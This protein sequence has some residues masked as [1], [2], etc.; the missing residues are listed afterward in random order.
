MPYTPPASQSP[1]ASKTITPSPSET[2]P[3]VGSQQE[4]THRHGSNSKLQLPHSSSSRAYLSK[5]RRSPSISKTASFVPSV[6]TS[7]GGVSHNIST[8]N[9]DEPGY[10]APGIGGN[11]LLSDS[12]KSGSSSTSLNSSDDEVQTRGGRIRDPPNLAEL[13][14]AIAI[15][16]QHREGSPNRDPG[17][18]LKAR[19][20]LGL[21]GLRID[22]S[23]KESSAGPRPSSTQPLSATARKISHSRSSTDVSALL[24]LPKNN[25][26]SPAR[27]ASDSDIDDAEDDP[28]HLKPAMIR[29]KSGE[30]VRPALRPSC[31]RRR[32]SSMPGTPTY[33]KAVHFDSSLE[34]VRHFLQVDRPIAVSAGTSPVDGHEDDTEFPFGNGYL[35]NSGRSFEWEIRLGNFPRGTVERNL[36]PVKVEKIYLSPDNKNLMAGIAVANL[37]FHKLV[38]A[39]FTLDYWKTTSEVVADYNNDV[40]RKQTNDGRDRFVFS[41]KLEDQANLESKT[42]F[43]CVRYNVNGQEFWDNNDSMNYQVD[44]TKKLNSEANKQATQGANVGLPRSKSSQSTSSSRPLSFPTANDDFGGFGSPFELTPFPQPSAQVIGESPI[45]LKSK[46]PTAQILPDAPGRRTNA[47]GQ[48]F[49][50]RYD[51]GASLSAAIQAA[52]PAMSDRGDPKFKGNSKSAPAKQMTFAQQ[53]IVSSG[54]LPSSSEANLHQPR[55]EKG[56]HAAESAQPSTASDPKPAALSAEKPSL[57]STSYHELLN[58]YCF[59]G[60]NKSQNAPQ[61]SSKAQIGS[62]A[63]VDGASDEPPEPKPKQCPEPEKLQPVPQASEKPKEECF[64]LPK[65]PSS[66]V[67]RS[68]S[69]ASGSGPRS[70]TASPVSFG[71]PYTQSL[72]NGFF[73]ET[74]APTAIR[75]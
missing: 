1:V 60:S 50:S 11:F 18:R 33:S 25:F 66:Q 43:F 12:G 59:F 24:N 61:R 37:A 71:Y 4:N 3:H 23:N 63:Q 49:G 57:Q 48:A 30:L 44:F 16:E 55:P 27:S 34:H 56:G 31:G 67:S 22:S 20:T 70:R 45:R 29:K 6:P 17:Q 40:R 7:A 47:G 39:R 42:L 14:A 51:F 54:N 53:P 2:P 19:A 32:P 75:G 52:S 74:H 41:V 10:F 38:V 64:P 36:M 35:R 8:G 21:D 13:Q 28:L 26:D 68:T 62:P 46:K 73:A 72:Q 15:I 69:P 65:P 58:K 5:H 9:K